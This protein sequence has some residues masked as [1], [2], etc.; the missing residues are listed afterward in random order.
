[1]SPGRVLI[2]AVPAAMAVAAPAAAPAQFSMEDD[3]AGI[4]A[5]PP[6]RGSR[7]WTR[8]SRSPPPRR[9]AVPENPTVGHVAVVNELMNAHKDPTGIMAEIVGRH[10][11][12]TGKILHKNVTIK[13]PDSFEGPHQI[14]TDHMIALYSSIEGDSGAP[15]LHVNSDSTRLLGIHVGRADEIVLDSTGEVLHGDPTARDDKGRGITQ[16]SIFST[17]ENV[18]R[19]LALP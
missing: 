11:Q 8:R 14:F 6:R 9:G 1:M 17:W 16:F 19:D 13:A 2:M 7:W 3:D 10:T 4:P 18:R 5:P 15:I 12:S